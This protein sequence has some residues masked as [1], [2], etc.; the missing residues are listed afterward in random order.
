[1]L[2][3]RVI[4]FPPDGV[5]V[6]A[7]LDQVNGVIAVSQ[8]AGGTSA[9]AIARL[10]DGT[11]PVHLDTGQSIQVN[12]QVLD[13]PTS[14]NRYTQTIPAADEYT[15]TVTEP[16]R[17][18]TQTTLARP[19][20]FTITAPAAGATASLSGFTINWSGPDP[21]LDVEVVV[22]QA[23]FGGQRQQTFGPFA[24]SGTLTLSGAE[25]ASFQ[26]GAPLLLTVRKISER[27]GI[28]G[29]AAGTLQVHLIQTVS[30]VPGP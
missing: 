15:V 4:V 28:N 16:T 9:T 13:G 3:C 29:L 21:E 11:D 30:V 12:G 26:Q 14:N 6:I 27:T 5:P 7:P 2:G 22:T 17:G 24:D 8:P 10:T 20:D 23:I 19:A 18:V 25:L 1:M